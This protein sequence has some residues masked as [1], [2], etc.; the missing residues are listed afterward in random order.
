MVGNVNTTQL[1]HGETQFKM[2]GPN[3]ISFSYTD[4]PKVTVYPG[5]SQL[6]IRCFQRS[7]ST[8]SLLNAHCITSTWHCH[9]ENNLICIE[10]QYPTQISWLFP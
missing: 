9:A 4:G 10:R 8:T 1:A 6:T 5:Q 2:L 7:S 3:V